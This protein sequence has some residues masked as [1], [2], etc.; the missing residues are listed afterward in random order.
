MKR[1]IF[2]VV[3]LILIMALVMTSVFSF[4]VFGEESEGE[5]PESGS[6]E[7][8]NTP[9]ETPGEEGETNG[10]ETPGENG[11]AEDSGNTENGAD[12]ENTETP[13]ENEETE[14]SGNTEGGEES[15]NTESGTEG[16]N[17][18][19]TDSTEED[20]KE[21]SDIL[22]EGKKGKAVYFDKDDF[23]NAYKK[24]TGEKFGYIKI[25]TLPSTTYGK[26]YYDYDGE[27]EETIKKNEKLYSDDLD[28]ISF[29]PKKEGTTKITYTAYGSKTS[30][31]VLSGIIEISIEKEI[32][33]DELSFSIYNNKT[34]AF[35]GD[36]FAEICD[37]ATDKEL[38]AIVFTKLPT[39]SQGA[40]YY[41]YRGDDEKKVTKTDEFLYGSDDEISDLYFVP[42]K[43]TSGTITLTYKGYYTS[44][45]FY[46]GKIEIKVKST[47]ADDEDDED[48]DY[49]IDTLSFSV[50]NDEELDLDGDEF[51]DNLEDSLDEE[52]LAISFVTLP[53]SSK[54]ILYY[55][56]DGNDEEKVAKGDKYY[57]DDDPDISDIT[58]VPDEDYSGTV[59]FEYRA[60]YTSSK[61]YEGKI[62]VKVKS[63]SGDDE[64]E[65]GDDEIQTITVEADVNDSVTMN[66]TKINTAYKKVTGKTLYSIKFSIPS[67]SYGTL[68]Y[69]YDGD[70]EEKVSSS[71][72][73]Y[74][75]SE[76]Y[77]KYVSF[78]P[79]KNY[80][81]TVTL[82]YTG[83]SSSSSANAATGKIKI[84]Y[85]GT[86]TESSEPSDKITITYNDV[87][88][89]GKK[90]TF[91]EFN[92]ACLEALDESIY[93]IKLGVMNAAAGKL[94]VNYG[95]SSQTE[96]TAGKNYYTDR[97]PVI[98]DV[99]FIPQNGFK[100]TAQ[101]SFTGYT[102]EGESFTGYVKFNVKS[103]TKSFVDVTE[104]NWYY[105]NVMTVCDAGLMQGS[106]ETTF[107][108]EGTMTLAEAITMAARLYSSNK[109]DNE[110]FV[111]TGGAWYE[112]YVNYAIKNGIIK[113]G[114]FSDYGKAAT[115]AEMA[116]IF[117]GSVD[118]SW[119]NK[120]NSRTVP[121]VSK[122]SKYGKE[123][124]A[125]YDAGIL[126]G[127]D[128]AGT[129][130]PDSVIIRAEA[131][132]ILGRTA[133]IIS[134]VKK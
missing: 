42:K 117:Y 124:Y 87:K 8:E 24:A 45:K 107:N 70:D 106:S 133:Y 65:E 130:R 122:D 15:G 32:E 82:T 125:L 41:D 121:D 37:D 50:Y 33:A 109:K 23:A 104:Q 88:K 119:L 55:D 93:Y 86:K 19:N 101:V 92:T 129:F 72:K 60:Y 116:Y 68:Y 47:T 91:G 94:Y 126:T 132:I 131:A 3:S 79:K 46:E 103:F 48:D 21:L 67:S 10:T 71:K 78:I 4:A 53:S 16:E 128:D 61:Y 43:G 18:G 28:E 31:P 96:H 108:P 6:S 7:T 114:D 12:S 40:I 57:Y 113:E 123:I 11:G 64:D 20:E 58:F 69:D 118:A 100:G 102:Y 77:I 13:G 127:S 111:P 54:G 26:L 115:R 44:S 112:V 36:E 39:T 74:S 97:E 2:K 98:T 66:Y 99:T 30:Y 110:T 34:L 134:R 35:D 90:L 85:K 73:Y 76:P 105:D 63:S 80:S 62:S 14:D 120:I 84:T 59:T 89:S 29:V 75:S 51:F 49:D 27:D 9:V 81:G 83:Y 5:N 52:L 25:P 56:F 22:Y 95:T 38:L 1:S 17:T